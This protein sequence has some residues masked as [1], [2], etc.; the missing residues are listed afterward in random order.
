MDENFLVI[1]VTLNNNMGVLNNCVVFK[2]NEK[3]ETSIQDIKKIQ[4]A[5]EPRYGN[6]YLQNRFVNVAVNLGTIEKYSIK[7]INK[8]DF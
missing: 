7:E 5:L 4:D 2:T 8:Y 6:I 3:G 1:D